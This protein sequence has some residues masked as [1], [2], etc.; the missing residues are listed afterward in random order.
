MSGY[1]GPSAELTVLPSLQD[2]HTWVL[3]HPVTE[4]ESDA[5]S[6]LPMSPCCRTTVQCDSNRALWEM[7]AYVKNRQL[8]ASTH[9]GS[10]PSHGG[11]PS[12]VCSA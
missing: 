4:I 6:V 1:L 5:L 2:T 7:S 3:T 12:A 11:V 10:C 9:F 8:L